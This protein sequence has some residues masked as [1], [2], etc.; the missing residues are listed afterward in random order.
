MA[1]VHVDQEHLSL[2][3]DH[4]VADP[5]SALP[6]HLTGWS[7]LDKPITGEL[8]IV[9]KGFE[10]SANIR[11]FCRSRHVSCAHLKLDP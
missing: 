6:A 3:C 8:H 11:R 4:V 5:L 9:A 10:V 7:D 1:W 2:I